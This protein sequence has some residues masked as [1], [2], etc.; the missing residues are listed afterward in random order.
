MFDEPDTGLHDRCLDDLTEEELAAMDDE[1][2]QAFL[3]SP[4]GCQ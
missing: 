3:N 4:G 2:F 1:E